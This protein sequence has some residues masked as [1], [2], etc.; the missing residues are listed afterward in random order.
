MVQLPSFSK[1]NLPKL[2]RLATTVG[3]V[4]VSGSPRRKQLL[5][6]AGIPFEVII[7]EVD[8]QISADIPP[9]RLVIE[10]ARQKVSSIS[11]DAKRAY[12]GCDTIVV[13]DA[14]ILTKPVDAE[15]AMRIL[16]KLSGNHHSVFTGLCLYDSRLDRYHESSEESRVSFNSFSNRELAEYIATGEPLDKAGAYGIQGMGG[17]LV[18]SVEGNVDNVVGLPMGALERLAAQYWENYA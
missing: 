8:E 1:T 2:D 6:A 13:L 12:L 5:E 10:L 9:D 17:F 14:E 16:R 7:P 11:G 18:D 15:D 3:L 4:L